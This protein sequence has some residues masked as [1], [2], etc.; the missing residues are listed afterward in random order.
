[1]KKIKALLCAM[2][3]VISSVIISACGKD[4]K[5][6]DS[7]KFTITN[8]EHDYDGENH[9][10]NVGYEDLEINVAYSLDGKTFTND[11]GVKEVG[12][13]QI[14]YKVTYEGYEEYTGNAKFIVRGVSLTNETTTTSYADFKAAYDNVK[15]SNIETLITIKLY[16]NST[17]DQNMSI[18][19]K[20]VVVDLN[21]YEL[22]VD[23]T[24]TEI[25]EEE[26]KSASLTIKNGNLN[27]NLGLAQ[28]T[29]T[30]GI[31]AAYH[32][33]E[34]AS[35][36]LES[37]NMVT[38]S[39][40]LYPEGNA[41]KLKVVS[42]KIEANVYAVTTNANQ[43][44]NIEY[45]AVIELVN[46]EFVT[47]GRIYDSTDGV[48][49]DNDDATILINVPITVTITNSKISGNRQAVIARSGTITITDSE[50]TFS[51][52][53]LTDK[54]DSYLTKKWD[55]G[56]EVVSAAVVV[57]DRSEGVYVYDKTTT[58]KIT[59]SKI[60]AEGYMAVYAYYEGADADSVVVTMDNTQYTGSLIN[61]NADFKKDNVAVTTD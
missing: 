24:T 53:W 39:T 49:I 33:N 31:I 35:M 11:F 32:I 58:L 34:G 12:E 51:G 29:I 17:Y 54:T 45:P 61:K 59:N 23:G 40:A 19:N 8:T 38:D 47:N 57:G 43:L 14:Y 4:T 44:Q 28:G 6:F 27:Y 42:S 46:S 37:V 30:E 18:T 50:I 41:E 2:F 16:E 9:K 52:K 3:L 13:Y 36:T 55:S 7:S 25:V 60:S 5:T 21:N 10:F 56:N 15:S 20:N 22:N 26:N 1:M 48:V